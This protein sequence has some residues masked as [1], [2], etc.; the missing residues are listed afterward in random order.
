MQTF[1][2]ILS[3]FLGQAL[4][5]EFLRPTDGDEAAGDLALVPDTHNLLRATGRAPHATT[6][7]L[8]SAPL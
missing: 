8:L 6:P 5:L 2:N 1:F 4:T 7:L 3:E